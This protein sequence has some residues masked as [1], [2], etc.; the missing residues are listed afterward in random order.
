M[1]SAFEK[2]LA[3]KIFGLRTDKVTG[4]W[5]KLLYR[6]FKIFFSLPGIKIVE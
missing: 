6:S 5:R 4:D 3:T 1:S 2:N